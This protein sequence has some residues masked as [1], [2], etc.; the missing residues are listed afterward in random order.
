MDRR[1]KK[2]RQAL[3]RAFL[4]LLKQRSFDEISIR[5]ITD[6][7]D[8]AYSTFFRNFESKEALL[9]SYLQELVEGI[10]A[11]VRQRS[12]A[13]WQEKSRFVSYELFEAV[14]EC[15]NTMRIM[16]ANSETLIVL[17]QFKKLLLGLMTELFRPLHP[18]FRKDVPV[19]LVLN[20]LV[21]Q[22]FGLLEWWLDS[23][24]EAPTLS[25]CHYY[26][27]LILEPTLGILLGEAKR[28]EV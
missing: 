12:S 9:L 1:I 10:Q 22:A 16:S 11:E 19:E 25:I 20:N 18:Q 13:T 8:V 28:L 21:V 27:T 7:A 14:R 2:T 26:E 17:K 6:R 5:D 23:D 24:L 15:P 4:D 3:S